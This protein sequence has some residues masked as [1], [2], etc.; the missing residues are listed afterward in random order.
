[1][2]LADYQAELEYC[3]AQAG[4]LLGGRAQPVWLE[5]ELEVSLQRLLK[6]EA[7]RGLGREP[8][9][10]QLQR[11]KRGHSLVAGM[12][13]FRWDT[14][15]GTV[16]LVK[17][18]VPCCGGTLDDF[19]AVRASDYRRFYRLLRREIR[20][21]GEQGPPVMSDEKRQRLWENTIGFLRCGSAEMARYGVTPRRGVLLLGEPGNGKTMAC[22]WLAAEA[23]RNALEWKSISAEMYEDARIERSVPALFQL[24]SPGIVLFDDFDAAL[25]DRQAHAENEKHATFLAELDGLEQK[26]GI[27]YLFTSNAALKDLDPA[28]RRPGRIDVVV[29]FAKPEASLRRRLIS[30][31]WHPELSAGVDVETVVAETDGLSFAEIEELKKLLVIRRVETGRWDWSWARAALEQRN[32]DHRPAGPIGFQRGANGQGDRAAHV[33]PR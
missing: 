7:R 12:E 19:W 32:Q 4:R 13:R 28:I 31:R 20:A 1:M 26:T 29:Q 30:E 18:I 27:V 2:F 10:L 33:L 25:L 6:L 5:W 24:A 17:V 14:R 9:V 21:R 23:R 11:S 16:R 3:L 8:P 22:R 15:E